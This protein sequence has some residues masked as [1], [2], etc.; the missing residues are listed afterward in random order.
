MEDAVEDERQDEGEEGEQA[1]AVKGARDLDETA[2]LGA[3]GGVGGEGA[4]DGRLRV[5][6]VAERLDVLE[7]GVDAEAKVGLDG[8]M[9]SPS[10]TVEAPLWRVGPAYRKSGRRDGGLAMTC[11]RVSS[12]IE[13]ENWGRR[14]K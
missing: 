11:A 3:R 12:V 13:G 14:S 5:E 6:G 8:G 9:A 1:A 10:S 7:G 2:G 4:A